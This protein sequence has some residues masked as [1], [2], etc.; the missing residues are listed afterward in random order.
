MGQVNGTKLAPPPP[1]QAQSP[2]VSR[3]AA[4]LTTAH[5]LP[6][7]GC[8]QRRT[9]PLTTASRWTCRA[10]GNEAV[11]RKPLLRNDPR[12]FWLHNN[13]HLY[14]PRKWTARDLPASGCENRELVFS[15]FTRMGEAVRCRPPRPCGAAQEPD[16]RGGTLVTPHYKSGSLELDLVLQDLPSLSRVLFKAFKIYFALCLFSK[17]FINTIHQESL[18]QTGREQSAPG[19]DPH[20]A[21]HPALS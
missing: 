5:I 6:A 4:R 10:E 7:T 13:S 3:G 8:E 20:L 15:I 18:T 11:L 21:L 2:V 19:Q 12:I 1:P 9:N 14:F 16:P 17:Y